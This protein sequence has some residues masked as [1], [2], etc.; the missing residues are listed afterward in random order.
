MRNGRTH[1][2]ISFRQLQ[3][4]GLFWAVRVGKLPAGLG[5]I[6]VNGAR[7]VRGQKGTRHLLKHRVADLVHPQVRLEKSDGLHPQTF[8]NAFNVFINP[9]RPGGFAALGTIQAIYFGKSLPMRRV[10]H[11][12]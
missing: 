7:I 6:V 3:N 5:S 9:Y 8:R 4:L 1:S 10:H 11:G 2:R 12:V